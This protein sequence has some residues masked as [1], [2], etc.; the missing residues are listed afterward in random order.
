MAIYSKKVVD[1]YAAIDRSDADSAPPAGGGGTGGGGTGGGTGSGTP[2]PQ[3]PIVQPP[4]VQPP[5]SSP[6][7]D[8]LILDSMDATTPDR[9]YVTK[10]EL[11]VGSGLTGVNLHLNNKIGENG[12]VSGM[13]PKGGEWFIGNFPASPSHG[14]DLSISN[15]DGGILLDTHGPVR[16]RYKGIYSNVLTDADLPVQ[17]TADGEYKLVVSGGTSSWKH[18]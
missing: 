5:V 6:G 3:P 8:R 12:V 9:L 18:I 15:P 4:V 13:G 16:V 1:I 2:T 7:H 14:Y 10:T 11:Y 17:P